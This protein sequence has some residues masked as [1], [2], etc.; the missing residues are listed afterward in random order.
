MASVFLAVITE[1]FDKRWYFQ[2]INIVS[3]ALTLWFEHVA[4]SLVCV[5]GNADGVFTLRG[6]IERIDGSESI[7]YAVDVC[8]G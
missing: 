5:C 3:A 2:P 7:K 6:I 8:S 1:R 4:P